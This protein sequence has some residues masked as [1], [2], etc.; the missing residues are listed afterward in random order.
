MNPKIR[1][2]YM[3]SGNIEAAI[4]LSERLEIAPLTGAVVD[5]TCT[6]KQDSDAFRWLVREARAALYL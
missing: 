4:S 5:G 3:P 1:L 6:V 2:A